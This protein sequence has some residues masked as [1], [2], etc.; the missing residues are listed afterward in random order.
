MLAA[1]LVG[2]GDDEEDVAAGTAWAGVVPMRTVFDE[3]VP[4]PDLDPALA[5]P[6]HVTR[7]RAR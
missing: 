1:R 5:V 7:A 3:P 4:A 2:P 6:E